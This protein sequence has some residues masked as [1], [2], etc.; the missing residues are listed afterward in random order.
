M[1][2]IVAFLAI[3]AT[4]SHAQTFTTRHVRDV[5]FS[6]QAPSVGQLPAN[7]TMQVD[8]VLP[9]RDKVELDAFV[10]DVYDPLSPNFHNFLTPEETS[11]RLGPTQENWD[12]LVSFAR[13]NGFRVENGS[14]K[15]SDLVLTGTVR[16]RVR[17]PCDDA[18]LSASHGVGQDHHAHGQRSAD[19]VN[20]LHAA[21]QQFEHGAGKLP[22]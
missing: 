21:H 12:A 13:A 20:H 7:Q 3:V 17:V 1:F 22:L 10:A 19:L 9:L 18:D 4:N 14:L 11:A 15:K 16:Y 5:V 6:G 8:V 2:S